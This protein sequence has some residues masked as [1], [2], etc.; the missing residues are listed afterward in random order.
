M[1]QPAPLDPQAVLGVPR[2]ALPRHVG[3]IMDGN[4]RW[5]QQRDLPRYE[6][7]RAG[8]ESVREA[9]THSGRLGLEVLTLFSFSSENWRRPAQEV[10]ALMSLCAHH[11]ADR[12]GELM[13]NNVRLLQIGERVG[14]PPEVLRELDTTCAATAGNTGLTLVLALNYGA[15]RELIRGIQRLAADVAAGKLRPEDIDEDR[16]GGVLD[17]AGLPDP[18]LIIRTA[19][20][21]RLSNFLLWQASY[22]EFYATPV[23]W[24]DFRAAELNAALREFAHRQRRFG[25]VVPAQ[26][27]PRP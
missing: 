8:V 12:R 16:V 14:L 1:S 5:A 21:M 9:S 2:S 10:T 23:L 3:I 7:H 25:D 13:E 24:P 26:A 15:R 4:G 17:T 19:G 11:L 6:G 20:E 27:P 22:A 18:D